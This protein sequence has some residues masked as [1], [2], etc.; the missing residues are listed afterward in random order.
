MQITTESGTGTKR[1]IQRLTKSKKSYRSNPPTY[2][3]EHKGLCPLD[4]VRT[5]VRRNKIEI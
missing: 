3:E 2:V 5:R 1:F 4:I